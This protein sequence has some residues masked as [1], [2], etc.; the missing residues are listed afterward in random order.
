MPVGKKK[1]KEQQQKTLQHIYSFLY[2]EKGQATICVSTTQTQK[3]NNF[4]WWG[5]MSAVLQSHSRTLLFL[6]KGIPPT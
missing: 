1:K 2:A 6:S 5:R 3:E 4:H